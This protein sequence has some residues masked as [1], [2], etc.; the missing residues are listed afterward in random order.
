[1]ARSLG[2]P[3]VRVGFP[4][5]DRLH[6]ARLR[7]LGYPGTQELLD[8]ISDALIGAEQAASPVGYMNY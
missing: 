5:H 4:V 6:G 7:L 1:M 3:L 2:L 8:R